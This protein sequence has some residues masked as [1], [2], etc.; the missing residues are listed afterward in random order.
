MTVWPIVIVMYILCYLVFLL[1]LVAQI[2]WIPLALGA[3][4]LVKCFAVFGAE[5]FNE[6][7][8]IMVDW[9]QTLFFFFNFVSWMKR[10]SNALRVLLALFWTPLG[11]VLAPIGGLISWFDQHDWENTVGWM[12]ELLL[13]T[14]LDERPK[15]SA[16]VDR[17]LFDSSSEI[18]VMPTVDR[19]VESG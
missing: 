15:L 1:A 17:W 3:F 19:H 5:L 9:T 12:K 8:L 13:L 10:G 11:I 7:N 14:F 18:P 6:A 2:A 4:A 16:L